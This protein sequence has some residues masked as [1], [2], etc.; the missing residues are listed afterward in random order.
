M[1]FPRKLLNDGEDVIAEIRPHWWTFAKPVTLTVLFF[2]LAVVAK[3]AVD[4]PLV[5]ALL[6][7]V[8]LAGLVWALARYLRWSTTL[9]VV[10]TD[11]LILR[12]GVLAKRGKE[13]PLERLNDISV[14]QTLFERMIGAGDLVLQSGG[15]KGAQVVSNVPRPFGVQNVV[16]AEIERAS[17]RAADRMAG[18]RE[19][20]IP[21]QIEKL[22]ELRRRGALTQSEFDAKKTQLL[23]RM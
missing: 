2:T 10:T 11:R 19:L 15:E 1:P 6:A 4:I 9:F 18:R 13:M 3:A 20:S 8:A 14:S 5:T 7:A 12:D 21:E 17:A 22:D 23:E 16:Y